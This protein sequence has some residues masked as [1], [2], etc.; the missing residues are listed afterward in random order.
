MMNKFAQLQ[1]V[2]ILM[3][4]LVVAVAAI[5]SPIIGT[6]MSD[7]INSSN[8]TGTTLLLMQSVVPV[9]WIG[10]IITFFVMIGLG[11]NNRQQ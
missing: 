7:A 9:F 4:V 3:F 2:S 5:I 1:I 6:F 11:G 10:I 8:A